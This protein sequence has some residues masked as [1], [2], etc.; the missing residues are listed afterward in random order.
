MANKKIAVGNRIS[1]RAI[2][3]AVTLPPALDD[4][5]VARCRKFDQKYSSVIQE[6]V[7]NAKEADERGR[8]KISEQVSALNEPVSSGENVVSPLVEKA[9]EQ[10]VKG[11]LARRRARGKP[12]G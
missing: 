5:V 7:R 1:E 12:N 9:G 10:L 3:H 2:K 8:Y 11:H 6:L 4:W